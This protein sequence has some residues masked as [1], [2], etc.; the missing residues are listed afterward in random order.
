MGSPEPARYDQLQKALGDNGE[1]S[2]AQVRAA[3]LALRRSKS[4]VYDRK[5][6]NHRSAGSFFMNPRLLDEELLGLEEAL[7][8]QGTDTQA[9]P[10]YPDGDRWKVPAAWLIEA[11][12]FKRG[13]E[14]GP[15]GLSTNH[16]LA[17]INRGGAQ[18]R[19]LVN[20]AR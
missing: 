2:L 12:G 18:A 15:V 4:M 20:L 17:L 19:D 8:D 11:A 10:R 7:V 16:S 1:P 14:R 3:V 6:S 9:L 5:D 13:L